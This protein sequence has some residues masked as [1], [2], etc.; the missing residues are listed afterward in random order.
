ML[1]ASSFAAALLVACSSGANKADT[2]T[3]TSSGDSGIGDTDGPCEEGFEV[4][5]CPPDFTLVDGSNEPRSLTEFRGQP[6]LIMGTA[7]W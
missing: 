5:M 6:M 4:G 1:R 7:E 3:G 2:S